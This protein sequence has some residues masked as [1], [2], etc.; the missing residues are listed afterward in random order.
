[1]EEIKKKAKY[2]LMQFLL[3]LVAETVWEKHVLL[4]QVIKQ[5]IQTAINLIL[6]EKEDSK[7]KLIKFWKYINDISL[8][9]SKSEVEKNY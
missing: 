8:V 2:Y 6:T 5:I 9:E 1:M 4:Q 3:V 7:M